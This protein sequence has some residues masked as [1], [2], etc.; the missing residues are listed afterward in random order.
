[1]IIWKDEVIQCETC[2]LHGHLDQADPTLPGR[3]TPFI[4]RQRRET[5]LRSQATSPKR[6][7]A[8]IY[9]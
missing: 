6:S 1:M 5:Y 8:H 9:E 7:D 2:G 4:E 3:H